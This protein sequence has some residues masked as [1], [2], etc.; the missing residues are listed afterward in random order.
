MWRPSPRSKIVIMADTSAFTLRIG[1]LQSGQGR[2]RGGWT[3]AVSA[4]GPSLLYGLSQGVI[5]P[6][7]ALSAIERGASIALA[8]LVVSLM[9]V[10]SLV[11]NIPAGALTTRFGER[12]M[13]DS[14][15]PVT[16]SPTP[17]RP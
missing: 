15:R 5:A 8:G 11:S 16:R 9:G 12:R 14:V 13:N 7:I 6:I 1:G 10:G 2:W 17:P 4:Y 3:G